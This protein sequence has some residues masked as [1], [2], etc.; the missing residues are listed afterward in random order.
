MQT[1]ST[2]TLEPMQGRKMRDY[3]VLRPQVLARRAETTAWMSKALAHAVSLPPKPGK[4]TR[5]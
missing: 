3:V 1:L 2:A 5:A 4:A